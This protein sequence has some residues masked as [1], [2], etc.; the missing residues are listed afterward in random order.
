M[1]DWSC[2]LPSFIVAVAVVVVD[3]DVYV[4]VDVD[5]VSKRKPLGFLTYCEMH[6]VKDIKK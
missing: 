5:D 4:D 2:L 6:K 1:Q 3:V